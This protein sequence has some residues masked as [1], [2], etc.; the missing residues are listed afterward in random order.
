MPPLSSPFFPLIESQADIGQDLS[1]LW[2]YIR[3]KKG[4]VNEY[5]EEEAPK[6]VEEPVKEVEADE[7]AP[8]KNEE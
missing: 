7:E 1:G 8:A 2:N 6:E 5:A 3:C 4:D